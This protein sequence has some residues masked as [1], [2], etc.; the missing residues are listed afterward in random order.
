ME[1]LEHQDQKLKIMFL[2]FF[3]LITN[4]RRVKILEILR[5]FR[6]DSV[7]SKNVRNVQ[8]VQ[9]LINEHNFDEL[10]FRRK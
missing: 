10:C 3:V 2:R 9:T 4:K 8:Q 1:F 6:S 5:E 7:I